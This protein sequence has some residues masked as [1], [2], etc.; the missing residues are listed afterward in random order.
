[1]KKTERRPLTPEELRTEIK[2][3]KQR[4]D[5]ERRAYR[6]LPD[7]MKK[8]AERNPGVAFEGEDRFAYFPDIFFD[9]Q[10]L[11]IEIDGGYHMGQTDEDEERDKFF[12]NHGYKTIHIKNADT[13]EELAFLEALLYR[14]R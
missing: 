3:K 7:G 5:Y 2:Q 14:L 11:L 10:R 13:M 12:R 4:T 9:E 1:M 8:Y 6:W